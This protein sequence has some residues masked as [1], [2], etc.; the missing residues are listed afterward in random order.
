[1]AL[2]AGWPFKTVNRKLNLVLNNNRGLNIKRICGATHQGRLD[3][4]NDYRVKYKMKCFKLDSNVTPMAGVK[5]IT[6]ER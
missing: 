2:T 4:R 3:E 6:V 1:M 5:V